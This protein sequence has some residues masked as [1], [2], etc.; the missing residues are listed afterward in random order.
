MSKLLQIL[1]LMREAQASDPRVSMEIWSGPS[2]MPFRMKSCE[3]SR[4]MSRPDPRKGF[5]R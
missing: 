2:S 3:P 4:T 1:G 5:L